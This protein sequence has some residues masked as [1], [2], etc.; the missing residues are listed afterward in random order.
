MTIDQNHVFLF[1]AALG[2]AVEFY[3]MDNPNI[4]QKTISYIKVLLIAL[5]LAMLPQSLWWAGLQVFTVIRLGD[6]AA[7]LAYRLVVWAAVKVE[8]W[9]QNRF[10]TDEEHENTT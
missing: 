5:S 4:Y 3:G 1:A 8:I 9:Q 10:Q 2:T 7:K 6:I